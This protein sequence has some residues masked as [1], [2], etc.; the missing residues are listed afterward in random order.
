MI[1]E[2]TMLR[3]LKIIIDA[4]NREGRLMS[5]MM[6]VM[7]KMTVRVGWFKLKSRPIMSNCPT[8]VP[9]VEHHHHGGD[10]YDDIFDNNDDDDDAMFVDK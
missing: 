8:H 1:V 7:M 9:L 10:F 2:K 5:L 3:R 4:D 6:M